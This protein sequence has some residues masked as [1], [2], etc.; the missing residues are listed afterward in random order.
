MSLTNCLRDS[1]FMDE[2]ETDV[3]KVNETNNDITDDSSKVNNITIELINCD[4]DLN[5]I[6]YE[7]LIDNVVKNHSDKIVNNKLTIDCQNTPKYKIKQ[8]LHYMKEMRNKQ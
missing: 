4:T 6:D 5:E 8:R 2:I 1:S 3:V 7:A